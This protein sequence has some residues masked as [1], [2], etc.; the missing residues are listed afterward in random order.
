MYG[1]T[2]KDKN[3]KERK[4]RISFNPLIREFAADQEHNISKFRSLTALLAA[5]YGV[6]I[7]DKNYK[8]RK[9]RISFNP[10]IRE[11]AADQEHNISK[12]RKAYIKTAN[13]SVLILG[14][15]RWRKICCLYMVATK[16]Y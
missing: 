11:F 13:C 15:R 1:V 3:Y 7:K 8:E 12:F 10:L 2:I 14:L 4:I 16:K 6:T 5:M 9:I